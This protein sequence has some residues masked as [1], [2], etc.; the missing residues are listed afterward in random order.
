MI[1][2]TMTPFTTIQVLKI[3]L[4]IVYWAGLGMTAA[5]VLIDSLRRMHR[6]HLVSLA[7]ASLFLG[8]T[9]LIIRLLFPSYWD[10]GFSLSI[11]F[12]SI[13]LIMFWFHYEL[14]RKETLSTWIITISAVITT[15]LIL[16][17]MGTINNQ[18]INMTHASL[19]SITVLMILASISLSIP[20]ILSIKEYL[21][22]KNKQQFIEA[23]G[24]L[25]LLIAAS[26]FY[27]SFIFDLFTHPFYVVTIFFAA[28]STITLSLAYLI[29]TSYLY[30]IPFDIQHLFCFHDSGLT[31]YHRTLIR[32]DRDREEKNLS[33]LAGVFTATDAIVKKI[34]QQQVIEATLQSE[35]HVIYF[36]RDPHKHVGISVI[37]TCVSWYLKQWISNLLESIPDSFVH[38]TGDPNTLKVVE[39]KP[40]VTEMN[41]IIQALFPYFEIIEPKGTE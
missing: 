2:T 41:R 28:C 15:I 37:T 22:F 5:I 17:V 20:L 26:F 29:N 34:L 6:I 27:L 39:S 33:F 35:N 36:K 14:M 4:A 7:F 11:L 18:F 12:Y 10:L 19:I 40:L 3:L 30:R 1:M 32:C 13:G 23:T 16:S 8:A 25:L 24:Y 9:S 38:E 31:F 21:S